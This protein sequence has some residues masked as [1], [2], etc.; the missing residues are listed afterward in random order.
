MGRKPKNTSQKF[1]IGG[2][3]DGISSGTILGTTLSGLSL[4][5]IG[6]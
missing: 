5:E 6:T 1:C 2:I 4:D 3:S